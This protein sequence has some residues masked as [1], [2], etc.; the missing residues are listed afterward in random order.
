MPFDSGLG[1][2][3]VRYGSVGVGL[4]LVACGQLI[5]VEDTQIQG[6]CSS[7][8]EC[9]PRY[10]CLL[11]ACRNGCASDIE[12]GAGARCLK[13]IGTSACIPASQGCADDTP[14][15]MGTRCQSGS[16]RT[17]CASDAECAGGQLCR[18]GLCTSSNGGQG[19][20]GGAGGGAVAA[21]AGFAGASGSMSA[22]GSG[23]GGGGAGQSAGAAGTAAVCPSV[24]DRGYEGRL[25]LENQ[26]EIVQAL[27]PFFQLVRLDSSSVALNRVKLRYYFTGE[28]SGPATTE[29]FWVT[30]D[31]CSVALLRIAELTPSTAN[32][33]HFI[34]LSF[35]DAE[36]SFGLEHLEVRV[37]LHYGNQNLRQTNDYSFDATPNVAPPDELP[38]RKWS[39]V[40]AYVDDELVWGREPCLATD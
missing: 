28:G 35:P 39:R 20:A 27:H 4:L 2:P 5:G 13:A 26:G 32:A 8:A 7:S 21:S 18:A 33:T 37:G 30:G 38:Y 11:G 10:E 40:T 17:S 12:C 31:A 9:A 25:Y 22:A 19:G 1:R 36:T 15:P 24:S 6:S 29:C 14:C 34:E 23:A 3:R 16:C